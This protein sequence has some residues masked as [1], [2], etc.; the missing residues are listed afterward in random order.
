M[1]RP[2]IARPTSATTS[3]TA[4]AA[5][6][7]R[8]SPI[9]PACGS[10]ARR[11]LLAPRVRPLPR[12]DRGPDRAPARRARSPTPGR[13][14][15]RRPCSSLAALLVLLPASDLAIACVQR[16]VVLRRRPETAAAPRLLRG[17]SRHGPD[18]GHRPDDADQLRAASTRCSST[19]RC[20]RSATS[21][22]ASTSPSSVIL[23]TR[24]RATAPDD[25]AILERAQSGIEALNLKFGA[26]HG[27]P[28]LPVSPRTGSGTRASRRG[29]AG[30]ASAA[31]SKSSTACCEAPPTRAS[32]PRSAIST[33][34][35]SVRYCITLDSDTRLPRDAAQAPDR[36]HRASA[37][38]AAFRPAVGTRHRRLR[39][40]AAAR[41]RDDGERG[42]FALRAHVRRPHRRRSVHD[43]RVRRLPGS[44]RRRHLHRQGTLRRRCLRGGARRARAGERA[45]LA[46]SVRGTL[47]AHGAGDRRRGRGRL[48]LERA[49]PRA[50]P[51]PL[52]ARRLA[53]S[54]VAVSRSCRRA[55]AWRAIACRSSRA[56]R[57]STTC[58]AAWCRRPRSLLLV[59]GWT[60]LPGHPLAWTRRRPAARWRSPV[61]HALSSSFGVRAA[62]SRGARSC[63]RRSTI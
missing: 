55:P 29:W 28:L 27:R 49:R 41:Q 16:A 60:V 13:R 19:S 35:P 20:W 26:E 3:S 12:R 11:A 22:R 1:A 6:S 59:L 31:R 34:L 32:R 8:T 45:A 15:A 63:A 61:S 44:L 39:D 50:A 47:R 57:S 43:G 52:G 7:K 10:R 21:I 23:P 38:P 48:P 2:A 33:V 62:G 9:G 25:E 51:A 18:D 36:H 4:G 37:E 24:T 17:R 53:D 46:R 54:L 14:A 58:G 40:P 30:S 42:G 56:G 5:I